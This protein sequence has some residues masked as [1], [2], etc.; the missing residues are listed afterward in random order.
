VP[1]PGKEFGEP[2]DTAG[3][4]QRHAR[5]AVAQALGHHRLVG[6]EQAAACLRVKAGSLLL[7][8][9]DG[10][11]PLR[12]YAARSRSFSSSSSR[13]TSAS[14]ASVNRRSWSP[15]HASSSAMPSRPS[16]YA[17]GS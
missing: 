16:R 4:V 6:G 11:D 5:L 3:G 1:S 13:L 8:G 14:Q 9:K 15:A 2:A 7:V 10:A 17:S 12:E